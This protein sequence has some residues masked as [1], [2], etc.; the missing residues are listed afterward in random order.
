MKR[1]KI[2]TD[3]PE[4]NKANRR[5]REKAKEKHIDTEAYAWVHTEIQEKSPQN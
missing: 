5:V 3:S 4:Q 2:E 1:N